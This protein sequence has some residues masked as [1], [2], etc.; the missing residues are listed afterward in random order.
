MTWHQLPGD[1]RLQVIPASMQLGRWIWNL[2]DAD[3]ELLATAGDTYS[4]EVDA[5]RGARR[6]YDALCREFGGDFTTEQLR[7]T[8]L[9]DPQCALQPGPTTP[10][11]VS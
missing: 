3:G 6:T 7:S 1:K 8:P 5:T 11:P 4:R 10:D 9:A 2:Y